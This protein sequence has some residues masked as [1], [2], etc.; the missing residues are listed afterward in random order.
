MCDEWQ[1]TN[2]YA[3]FVLLEEGFLYLL[4]YEYT[5][6]LLELILAPVI[7]VIEFK[8][9]PSFQVFLQSQLYHSYL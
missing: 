7:I 2:M 4:K 9:Q 3:D 8:S 6:Y 1:I 5:V